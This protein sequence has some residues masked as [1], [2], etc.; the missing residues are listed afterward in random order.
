MNQN[1]ISNSNSTVAKKAAPINGERFFNTLFTIHV[2]L[3]LSFMLFNFIG[4]PVLKWIF[5]ALAF[6]TFVG[7]IT[8]SG[9]ASFSFVFLFAFVEGQGRVL[10][11]YNPVV[12]VLFDVLL[13]LVILKTFIVKKRIVELKLIPKAVLI[14][15]AFHIL[16]FVVELFNP[17]GAGIWASLATTKYYIFPLFLF[18]AFLQNPLNLE[19]PET[20]KAFKFITIILFLEAALC[21]FQMYMGEDFMIGISANFSRLHK[22]EKFQGYFFRPF[23]TAHIP[24]GMSTFFYLT[25]GLAFLYPPKHNWDKVFFLIFLLTSWTALILLQVRSALLKHIA[26]VMASYIITFIAA[27]YKLRRMVVIVSGVVVM[28]FLISFASKRIPALE[29]ALN[30]SYTVKRFENLSQDGIAAQ[31]SDFLTVTRTMIAKSWFYP[32]GF[33]PGMF[34]DYLPAFKEK[35]K[36]YP[37]LHKGFFWSLDNLYV[38]IISELGIGGL[39]Y[40]SMIIAIPI[41]LLSMAI[42]MF[43]QKEMQHFKILALTFITI[44]IITIGNWGVVGIPF[45]PESFFYWFWIALA[46]SA[47]YRKH[48]G[49]DK[50]SS[51]QETN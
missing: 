21:I 20:R 35:R 16:W 42:K 15:M 24:G 51:E 49:L 25:I 18:F 39:F 33:G 14:L 47:Y 1:H 6:M 44:T 28:I 26:I 12:R 29:K 2:I 41:L 38:F 23:G 32:I 37:E 34:T 45:N 22:F 27:K 50:D 3:F 30:L 5:S 8:M 46:F 4:H 13:G 10:W 31:R 36:Q 17:L 43:R 9:Q 40:L 11:G 7:V 48:L 19:A